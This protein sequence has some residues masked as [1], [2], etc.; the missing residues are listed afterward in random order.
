MENI[1]V[2]E[3]FKALTTQ[4]PQPVQINIF[5]LDILRVIHVSLL[6]QFWKIHRRKTCKISRGCFSIRLFNRTLKTKTKQTFYLSNIE[7]F[8]LAFEQTHIHPTFNTHTHTPYPQNTHT[9]SP[10]HT[11]INNDRTKFP[12]NSDIK[13]LDSVGSNS[14]QTNFRFG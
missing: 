8:F 14:R 12:Q 11:T 9:P 5:Q 6:C 1:A 13:K 3:D 7:N 2:F 4:P 10:Q